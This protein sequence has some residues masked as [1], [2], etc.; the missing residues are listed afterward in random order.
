MIRPPSG[1]PSLTRPTGVED[2]PVLD[3][4]PHVSLPAE[5]TRLRA[6]LAAAI[7][8]GENLQVALA[9]N[10]RIGMAIGILMVTGRLPEDVAFERLR[11]ASMRRNVK[12]RDVAEDVIHTGTL[13]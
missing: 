1:D 12:L 9:S 7:E 10:R 5:V 8:H 2:V 3:G 4:A 11:E 13:E 6:E